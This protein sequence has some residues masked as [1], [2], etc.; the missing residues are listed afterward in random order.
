MFGGD[1]IVVTE[2]GNVYR[3]DAN[4]NASLLARIGYHDHIEG[5][6]V[7]PNDPARYG[8]LAGCV[9]VG[10]EDSGSFDRS[11]QSGLSAITAQ[12]VVT[13]YDLGILATNSFSQTES[14]GVVQPND[15]LYSD[16]PES[17]TSSSPSY[18]I[19]GVPYSELKNLTGDI[20]LSTEQ[21]LLF[22]SSG[23]GNRFRPRSSLIRPA[24]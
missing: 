8:P 13:F 7:L 22:Q 11:Q 21:G 10:Q 18:P 23:M 14:I 5:V 1:L 15:N 17:F 2:D 6:T 20:L 3:I 16:G 24:W 19:L 12:G 4:G 9:I